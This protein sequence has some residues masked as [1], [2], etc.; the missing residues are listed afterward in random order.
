MTTLTAAIHAATIHT[1]SLT[2]GDKAVASTVSA[3]AFA[4]ALVLWFYMKKHHHFVPWLIIIAIMGASASVVSAIGGIVTPI[5]GL[6]GDLGALICLWILFHD[7][8]RKHA[9]VITFVAACALPFLASGFLLD[10]LN[11]LAST[12]NHAGSISGRVG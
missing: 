8:K 4:L 1:N 6:T 3:A 2:T 10:L 5:F 7:F 11:L 12:A 9:G